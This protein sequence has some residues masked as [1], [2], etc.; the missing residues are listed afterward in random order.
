MLGPVSA[1]RG[2]IITFCLLLF[3]YAYFYQGGGPNQFSR[4]ALTAALVKDGTVRIDSFHQLTFDKAVKDGHFYT[5]KAP[6]LSLLAVPVYAL[7][8]LILDLFPGLD[9]RDRLNLVMYFL[10]LLSV[11]LPVAVA[12]AAFFRRAWAESGG[13]A[14]FWVTVALGLGSPL[15]VYASLFYG[16]ALSAALLWL[17]FQLVTPV[18]PPVPG[19]RPEAPFWRFPL[20]GCLAGWATLTELPTGLITGV[21]L[22]YVFASRTRGWRPALGYVLGGLPAL[23]ILLVYNTA[24]FGAPLAN[25]YEYAYLDVFR[26]QMSHGIMG[27]TGPSVPAAVGILVSPYRGLLFFWPF[28]IFCVLP[29]FLILLTRRQLRGPALLAAVI[30]GVYLVFGCSYYMWTGGASFGPRH[31][32][33]C[34]PFAAYLVVRAYHTSLR[35]LVPAVTVASVAI[36]LVAVATLAEFPEGIRAPLFTFAWPHF[37]AGVLSVKVIG[38]EGRFLIPAEPLAPNHPAFYDAC[39]LGEL[40]GLRGLASLVPLA[41]VAVVLGGLLWR[42]STAPD[43][44]PDQAGPT[45]GRA[46]T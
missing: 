38:P 2:T 24:A 36:V 1:R 35:W 33:P 20:A 6:G 44:A 46:Q 41:V 23:G 17:A 5:D 15:A 27:V 29:A 13:R 26:E 39:N 16:H 28:F 3:G 7:L 32:I 22:V 9:A 40:L 4:M 12:L 8:R 21:L 42:V 11:S 14:A 18:S 10:T 25:G 45:P 31:L 30:V 37:V 34:L 43:E 19:E